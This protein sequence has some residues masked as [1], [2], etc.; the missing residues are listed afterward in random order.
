MIDRDAANKVLELAGK[1]PAIGLLGPRQSGKTTLAK[2][3]F[4][5]KPYLSFEN[6]DTLLAATTD[7]RAFLSKYPE[8]A[9][10]DEIQRAPHLFSY[11]QG[12]IDENSSKT[13]LF[14][15]TGSQNF[16]LLENITQSLAGRIAF[17]Q[18][19]PF[20]Y[21]EL[22]TTEWKDS[23]IDYL[24]LQ[25]GYPRLYDK[26]IEP[27]DYYPNYILT[28]VERDVR[29]I[30]N[31]N[32]LALFQRFIKICATRTGQI[33]NYASIGNDCGIDIKTVI[34]WLGIL[35]T[36]FIAFT[37]KPF[38]NNLGKRL[39]QMPKLYFYDTGLCCSLLEIEH[40]VQLAN[41]PLR[42]SL[43]E[44]FVILELLKQRFNKGLRNS[45]YYW[46]DRTG[47]EIDILF[48][49]ATG[50]VPIEIKAG[51]TYNKSFLKGIDYWKKMQPETKESF[52]IYTG[53]ASFQQQKT[54]IM[55]WK[56]MDRIA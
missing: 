24:M 5:D 28:Y 56:E 41:H 8:G 6:Q 3:L 16:L 4:K 45:F 9:V 50:A 27:V 40:E 44:N 54:E 46:R 1:F 14:I 53:E 39:L 33:V 43:F 12:I 18:L 13:G 30:K 37:L 38:Y 36:S 2:T 22:K 23:T 11:L 25:G 34:S 48:D 32:S 49:K 29:Q 52:L 31:I 19:L 17:I 26:A 21:H 15:L 7:P 10:F 51:E 20:S 55:N 42:G 35:E 47:N